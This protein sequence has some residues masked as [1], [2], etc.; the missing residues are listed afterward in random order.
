[1]YSWDNQQETIKEDN[2]IYFQVTNNGTPESFFAMKENGYIAQFELLT[3]KSEDAWKRLF[4]GIQSISEEIR[5]NNVDS[6]L[7]DKIAFLNSIGLENHVDQY[8]MELIN[9]TDIS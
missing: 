3:G 7:K 1:M 8:E 5:I 4:S 6:W 9:R 2:Y